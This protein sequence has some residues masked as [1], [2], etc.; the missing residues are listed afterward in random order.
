MQRAEELTNCAEGSDEKRELE[1]VTNAIEA[2][3]ALRWPE[4]KIRSGKG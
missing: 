2:Y 3:E 1:H 4:G